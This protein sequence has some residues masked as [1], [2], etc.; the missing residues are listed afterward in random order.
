MKQKS[1]ILFTLFILFICLLYLYNIRIL[2]NFEN[3]EN[4]L[5]L[6]VITL[7][8]ENRL[9]NIKTQQSKI[10]NSIQLF[11]A[12]KGD[13]INVDT[14]LNEY[15]FHY[16]FF[17]ESHVDD[18]KKKREVGCYLSH[19]NLYK[20]IKYAHN[21][22]GYAIVFED[23]FTIND[24]FIDN[25]NK[26]ISNILEK[27]IDF[28]FIFLGQNQ[29]QN[30]GDTDIDNIYRINKNQELWGTHG[31]L[32]NNKNMDKILE[33]MQIVDTPV[34]V[35]IANLAK[36]GELNVFIIYPFI[37]DI[38]DSSST[39]NDLSIETFYPSKYSVL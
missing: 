16:N 10:P 37:V 30:K 18:K 39:I 20:L 17:N 3:N 9:Q 6:Y 21:D 36:S 29:T 27:N 7:K 14:I 12:V 34:D 24:D 38:I 32:I 11:E 26:I 25:I 8:H 31:L 23:D 28:D 22:T 35:K 13:F 2:D 5:H 15:K 4:S 19:L 33:K 1:W